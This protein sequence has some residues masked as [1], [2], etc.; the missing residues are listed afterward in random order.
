[1]AEAQE[2]LSNT[3]LQE[4]T[5]DVM[6]EALDNL[7]KNDSVVEATE[8]VVNDEPIAEQPAESDVKAPTFEEAQNA[9]QDT[10]SGGDTAEESEEEL[11][12]SEGVQASEGLEVEDSEVYNS[13][14][15]KA[16]ERF[17][18]WIDKAKGIEEE[19]N[20]M[21]QGNSQIADIIQTSTTNPQQLGWALE[22]FKGLNSGNYATAVDAL[23]ALDSF[24]DQV[25]KTLGVN[26]EDNEKSSYADFE[27]LSGA[28]ENLEMSEE[29]ATKLAGQRVS[30][31]SMHQAQ[32]HYQ[33]Y[34]N[35]QA[36]QMQNMETQQHAAYAQIETWE[37]NLTEKDP[38]YGLKKDIMIEMGTQLANSQVPPDQWLPV[39]Q[40][41]YQTL[42]RGM[43]VA[44]GSKVKA[45]RRSGPLA[46][47]SGNSGTTNATDLKQAEVTP[48]FLQAH[49]DALHS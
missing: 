8:E 42:S 27:D 35:Q 43:D 40:N 37:K 5:F 14:K 34:Q 11:Q 49:L 41:Q 24:S 38:D 32:N 15:P 30:Q 39:L 33:Q 20:T 1:M 16:Q 28:V 22:M 2:E 12:T 36:Q 7:H 9:Q 19:Y 3:E 21:I 10:R 44:G 18:H 17:K 47:G 46:P 25:A 4:S 31:N 6:S 48:E 13:L 23:K 26:S 29:W 45:S